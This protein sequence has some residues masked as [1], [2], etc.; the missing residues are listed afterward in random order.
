MP[1]AAI[2]FPT[3]LALIVAG[4][5]LYIILYAVLI[6]V[7][8]RAKH[9][10]IS[11]LQYRSPAGESKIT[12]EQLYNEKQ[13]YFSLI[14]PAYNEALRLP[15]MLKEACDY[16]DSRY[17]ADTSFTWEIIVIDDCSADGTSHF[18]ETF[19]QKRWRG[20]KVNENG[21]IRCF[22]LPQNLGKGGAV[23]TGIRLAKGAFILFADADGASRFADLDLLENSI[24]ASENGSAI[25]V[26][27]RAHLVGTDATVKVYILF[28]KIIA[29]ILILFF[30]F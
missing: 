20:K 7:T 17:R 13:I 8:P 5:A 3:F 11:S 16:L 29:A 26:G 23:T 22:R 4:T 12:E 2:F 15:K 9:I 25:A 1:V 19:Y 30:W 21:D 18:V 28:Y 6:L 27:S 10:D 14:I 24:K